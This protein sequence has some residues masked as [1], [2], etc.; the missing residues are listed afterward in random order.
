[1]IA[2]ERAPEDRR[3][4]PAGMGAGF[5]RYQRVAPLYDL[6]DLP[7]EYGR[8]RPL[9]RRMFADLSGAIL[10]AGVGTGRNMPFYPERCE[11]VGIDLSPAMLARAERRRGALGRHVALHQ[12]D[13]CATAF[14]DN[15]FDAVVAS[16]LFRVLAPDQQAPALGELGRICKPDG[17]I[18]ML[19][20]T[21]SE[22]PLRRFVMALWAPWVRRV[23]GA[24][25]DRR[26][27][28]YLPEASLETVETRFLYKDI[29][30]LIVAR[31]VRTASVPADPPSPTAAPEIGGGIRPRIAP[32]G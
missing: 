29:I 27:E 5:A 14:P 28:R 26:T 20:Y 31:P 7:F 16:F 17:E 6:L 15:A 12:M 2:H 1:M 23:Y 8:Y 32:C 22:D 25:F 13:V 4:R 11:V 30:K 21:R 19:E 24:G 18:R 9:R 3:H 10:D